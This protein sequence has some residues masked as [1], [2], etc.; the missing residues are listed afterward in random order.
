MKLQLLP[1]LSKLFNK[2]TF[3]SSLNQNTCPILDA[4]EIKK[5][6]QREAIKKLYPLNF[7]RNF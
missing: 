4:E 2:S 3:F 6:E 7:N 5:Q 1:P